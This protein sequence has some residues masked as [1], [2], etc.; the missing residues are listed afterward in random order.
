MNLED[1][2][3]E[4]E[5]MRQ[6]QK[7]KL[8]LYDRQIAEITDAKVAFLNKS[9]QELDAALEIQ[10]QLLGDMESVET[11]S[12]VISKKYPNLKSKASYKLSLPKSKEEKIRFERYMKEEHPGLIKEETIVKPI[13]N[14]IKQ[15][16]VDGVFHRT[17][18]GLLIDDNGMAI[19]NTTVDV[20]SV[21][22]KV[23]VKE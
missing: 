18:E 19:P 13:Q 6:V 7:S 4:I 17:E 10:R 21:E 16:I 8:D 5:M 14:D 1:I 22:V 20:K 9:K 12:F 15:L 3:R 2:T 23:K 11:E